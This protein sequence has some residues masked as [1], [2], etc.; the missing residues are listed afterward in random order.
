ML[1]QTPREL[2]TGVLPTPELHITPYDVTTGVE[3]AFPVLK[4][5]YFFTVRNPP[6]TQISQCLS[7]VFHFELALRNGLLSSVCCLGL[8]TSVAIAI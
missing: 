8:A 4:T 2:A 5:N 6:E 3:P 1:S 7:N